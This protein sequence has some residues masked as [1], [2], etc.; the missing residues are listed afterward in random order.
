MS[1]N[2]R[3]Q[4]TVVRPRLTVGYSV[5]LWISLAVY[6]TGLLW[7][8][9]TIRRALYGANVRILAYHGFRDGLPYIEMFMPPELFRRQ[10]A[11]LCRMGDVLSLTDYLEARGGSCRQMRD[12]FLITMDDGYRDN[13]EVALPLCRTHGISMTVFVTT[14][15]LQKDRPTFV[16]A[17]ILAIEQTDR[18]EMRL[19]KFGVPT[20]PLRSISEREEA[21]RAIDGIAK[22]M[23]PLQRERLLADVLAELSVDRRKIGIDDLMLT[24]EHLRTM[25]AAGMEI[26]AHTRTHPVLSQLGDEEIYDEV[27]GSLQA[28]EKELS[29]RPALFAYPYGGV[30]DFD[31]RAVQA[32]AQSG[33]RGAV[34]LSWRDPRTCEALRLGRDMITVDRCATPWGTHSSALFACEVA[35]LFDRLRRN[36]GGR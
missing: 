10:V 4:K 27:S 11:Q 13:F 7:V 21:I 20:F 22:L 8:F 12:V 28:L 30:A 17:L 3:T 26:G 2:A 24:S 29:E 1:L 32:C 9:R 14:D 31:D 6:Y 19:P 35:G 25:R 23:S 33:V 16:A 18:S 36:G 5:R 15:C 34:T